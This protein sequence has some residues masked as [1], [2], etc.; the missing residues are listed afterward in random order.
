MN[1]ICKRI[2]AVIWVGCLIFSLSA[3]GESTAEQNQPDSIEESSASNSANSPDVTPSGNAA[4]SESVRTFPFT[5]YYEPEWRGLKSGRLLCTVNGIRLAHS[6]SELPETGGFWEEAS[7]SVCPSQDPANFQDLTLKEGTLIQEDGQFY[8]GVYLL[9]VDL[10]ITSDHAEAYTRRD[11]DSMGN[12][13]G[14][15][16]DP[17]VFRM[18]ILV[19]LEDRSPDVLAGLRF[20]NRTLDYSSAMNQRAEHP[21]AFRLEPGQSVEMSMGFFVSDSNQGGVS[22]FD[23]LYLTASASILDGVEQ[24]QPDSFLTRLDLRQEVLRY[25]ELY[26]N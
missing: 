13:R 10:T 3:C 2:W 25:E 16:D 12:S 6:T 18:D 19:E 24:D 26:Q 23:C 5:Y 11:R 22:N 21:R 17:Y 8:P 7:V 4:E 15:Y 9:L 1:P 20:W 14:Q